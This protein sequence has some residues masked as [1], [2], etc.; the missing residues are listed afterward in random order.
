MI[1]PAKKDSLSQQIT[2]QIIKMVD[3]GEWKTGSKIPGE[4]ELSGMF[5]V[6]RNSIRE[7]LK[8]L[9]LMGIIESKT[10][11]GTFV[12]ENAQVN[13]NTMNLAQIIE[14]ESTLIDLME[15]R[16]IIEPELAAQAA[17]N[18]TKKDI[19]VLKQIL[20]E[21]K[22]ALERNKYVFEMGFEFHKYVCS[23]GDNKI[24]NNLL[25][26]VTD[27][28]IATRGMVFLEHMEAYKIAEEI[29]EHEIMLELLEKGD[30]CGVKNIMYN[31]IENSLKVIEKSVNKG[32]KERIKC[33]V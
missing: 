19:E 20:M 31:H 5:E 17:R 2:R 10:G 7:S 29:E 28:L 21:T 23:L 18:V 33:N 9:E 25:E 32:K 14:T 26:S 4:V 11:I 3:N 27:N 6:S 1:K 22:D 12:T 16:L 13:I 24:L 8:A 30:A 15:T